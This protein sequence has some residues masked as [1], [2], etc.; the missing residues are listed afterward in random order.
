METLFFLS[1]FG[2][3]GLAVTLVDR[4]GE[5]EGRWGEDSGWFQCLVAAHVGNASTV[6]DEVRGGG[7]GAPEGAGNTLGCA[8]TK[9]RGLLF[10]GGAGEWGA[11][12]EGTM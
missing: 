2:G 3:T 1:L 5:R 7:G 9:G 8:E 10:V 4:E 11:L 12:G 6:R